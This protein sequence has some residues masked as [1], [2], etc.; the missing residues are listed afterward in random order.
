MTL[1]SPSTYAGPSDMR[2]AY[3]LTSVD[4]GKR[5][6]ERERASGRPNPTCG[7][8]QRVNKAARGKRLH[9]SIKMPDLH[10]PEGQ[11]L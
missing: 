7:R 3:G 11:Q 8:R 6:G 5:A 10:L 4:L 9:A 1:I 2:E